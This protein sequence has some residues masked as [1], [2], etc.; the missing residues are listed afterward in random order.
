[1]PNVIVILPLLGRTN[2]LVRQICFVKLKKIIQAIQ[3]VS[4][5]IIDDKYNKNRIDNNIFSASIF[6]FFLKSFNISIN[7]F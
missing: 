3:F 2:T 5:A 1:M 7:T 4:H 6:F